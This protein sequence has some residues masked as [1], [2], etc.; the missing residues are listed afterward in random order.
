MHSLLTLCALG[1]L[2]LLCPGYPHSKPTE[3]IVDLSHFRLIPRAEYVDSPAGTDNALYNSSFVEEDYVQTATRLVQTISPGTSFRLIGNHYVGDNG[4]SHVYF[5]QTLHGIDIENADFNVNVDRNGEI[6][7]YGNSFFAGAFPAGNSPTQSDLLDPIIA[8]RAATE[9]L[10]LPITID[11]VTIAADKTNDTYTL[12]GTTGTVSDP[13]AQLV[14]FIT[15]DGNLALTWR[16]ETDIYDHW[17]LTYVDAATSERIHGVVDYVSQASYLV[18][19]WGTNDPDDGTRTRT[20]VSNPWDLSSS[21]YAWHSDGVTNFTTTRGNNAIAQWNPSG[22]RS[23]KNNYRPVSPT[24][25]F[26]YPYAPNRAT[27][28][29]AYINASITQLFY[30]VNAYHD[31]LY[32]LGFTEKAGNFEFNNGN[33]GGR[34]HDYVI[35]N[36]QDGSGNDN[37]N[38]AAPPDGIPGRMNMFLWT[39]SESDE[40]VVRDGSFDAGIVIH[41]YT[42]GLSTRLTG[43][44]HNSGCLSSLESAGMGEGWGDFMATAIRIKPADSRNTSY[45]VGAWAAANPA[46]VRAYPYSTS[47][48]ENPL[49]YTNVNEFEGVHG[50]GTVWASM[51]YEVMW[52]LMERYGI[53]RGEEEE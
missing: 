28:P 11:T 19:P 21:P 40:A 10:H 23:Y 43:G 15:A 6:F 46:G 53:S 34:P 17:L 9:T 7:S 36:A 45:T 41:E 52:Y 24:L 13:I 49:S 50:I 29:A 8:L 18:Y 5:R 3:S 51:L 30:T 38:F 20:I 12:Q 16:I 42:H 33:R 26:H 2:S 22:G 35:L 14:Y 31:L 27:H 4:V 44:P 37:A 48:T 47:L 1:A 32:Q 39:E 25:Q